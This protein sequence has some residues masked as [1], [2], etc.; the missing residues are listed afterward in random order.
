ME[1]K[2]RSI[3]IFVVISLMASCFVACGD[4]DEGGSGSGNDGIITSPIT[5]LSG[6]KKKIDGNV[7][8]A[9]SSNEF[10]ASV[11]NGI[12]EGEH[13]GNAIITVNNKYKIQV[14]VE[15]LYLIMD[16]PVLQWNATKETVKSLQHQGTV[17]AEDDEMLVY[18]NCG[19]SEVLTY[20]FK[21]GKLKSVLAVVPVS[22]KS[23]FVNYLTERY[24][25]YPQQLS[26]YTFVGMDSYSLDNAKTIVT[27]SVYNTKYLANLYMPASDFNSKTIQQ[28]R[29]LI[30][31]LPI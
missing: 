8:S 21:N 2:I 1:K 11:N 30:N 9:Q 13:I 24:A 15:P 29:K 25:F 23:S 6:G 5:L 26:N 16:D 3:M 17:F 22:K 31:N 18:Q 10:V 27:L 20:S 28:S 4:D 14:T 12:I 19:D 7:K